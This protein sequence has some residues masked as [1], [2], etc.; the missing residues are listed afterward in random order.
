MESHASAARGRLIGTARD[1]LASSVRRLYTDLDGAVTLSVAVILATIAFVGNGGLQLGSSTFVEIGVIVIGSILVAASF[2][3]VG[4]RAAVHGG[5]ALAGVA[6]LVVLTAL[7]ILWS[8]YPSDTW[9]ET[10]R[11]LAYLAAFAA[12]IAAV[13][14]AR[15]R[16]AAVA[17]GVLLALFAV[18]VY[19]LATK[20]AP[21]WL[22]PDE[23]YGRLREPYGYWN[24]VGLTA[25]LGI[26]L[27]L[28]LATRDE[29]R[30]PIS[31]AAY[32][33]LALFLVTMMLS[34]SR[35]SILAAVVG[36]A[37]WMV[38]VP[39]RLRGLALIVASG[40]AAAAVTAW[41]FSQGALTDDR[42]TLSARKHAGIEFGLILVAMVI[43]TAIAGY[44]IQ[45]RAERHPLAE[46][47][48][49][50]IGITSLCA[51]AAIPL[52]VLVALAFSNRGIG[53]TI[54]D[55]WH[56]LT[57]ADSTPRNTPGRLIQTGSVRTIYW[58]RALDVWER[59]K[60]AG[61][62]AGSFAEAQLRYRTQSAQ[63]KHA[64][65]YVHQTLA[66]LGL[67]G[68]AVS[69]AAL[70]AWLLAAGRALGLRPPRESVWT[71]ER[72]GLAALALVALVFGVH[73]AIDW[74]WFVPALA[75]T[76]LFCAGWI[77]GRGPARAPD[78]ADAAAG[79]GARMLAAVRPELPAKRARRFAFGT[80]AFV[81]AFGLLA[82]VAVSQPWR[83]ER[84]GN[85]AL[86]LSEKGDFKGA[87]AAARKA[88]DI[89]PLSIDPYLD[90]AAVEDA[91][92]DKQAAVRALEQAVQVQ[93]ASPEAWQRL[94]EY[95]LNELGQPAPALPILQ[96]AL[97][98][99]PLSSQSRADYVAA[100]RAQQAL[101]AQQ[102]AAAAQRRARAKS[103]R[104]KRGSPPAATST[105]SP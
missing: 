57:N 35:G 5:A 79:N 13:R 97:Y 44:A 59:H 90:M 89:D 18:S 43:V 82:A 95:R 32:P 12:G 24:A 21:A 55:R 16:W 102:A 11:T 9:V 85:D 77:A 92:G 58:G 20:V 63:A 104:R 72:Q 51:L 37:V 49:R 84:K 27:C 2:V 96:A 46:P 101:Q 33:M 22:N 64:H 50:R 36:I 105:K 29:G 47:I 10:N 71:S 76:G 17:W 38:I 26:P 60:L 98:L 3:L 6:A 66:D 100:L 67:I 73:S 25:A 41:A 15:E 80:A 45:R 87:L 39:L 81:L 54:S 69:L 19:A 31:V 48:R 103:V 42:V 1:G 8:L 28:W 56:D 91:A 52:V 65:G 93:P 62:G 4:L 68:L 53:G 78:R 99:D 14:I 23:V 83:S 88:E 30:R 61:A 74:T 40:V 86:A 94:G 34:F 7:S 75:V 70:A